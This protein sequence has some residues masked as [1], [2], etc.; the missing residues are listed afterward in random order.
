MVKASQQAH[1]TALTEQERV[2]LDSLFCLLK[3]GIAS[4]TV[5]ELERFTELFAR[6]LSGKGDKK[7]H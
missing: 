1:N 5:C 3:S 6:T 2:E 4:S 7:L